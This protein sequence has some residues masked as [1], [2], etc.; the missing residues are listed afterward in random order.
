VTRAKADTVSSTAE[1]NGRVDASAKR[2]AARSRVKFDAID[3]AILDQLQADSKITNATLAQRVGI[4]PPSTLERVKKLEA[5]GII[6]GYR[7]LIDAKAVN[8]TISAFVHVTLR[9]HGAKQLRQFDDA[10]SAFDE[11]QGAWHTAGEEDFMLRVLVTDMDEYERFVVHR[12]SKIPNIG[13]VRTSFCLSAVK[14]ETRV[15]LDAVGGGSVD[16]G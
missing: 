8:K 13:R 9:E 2:A 6:L 15:P 14:D 16:E 7:A 1:G 5:G 11:V 10:V 12:L 4:S 3:L